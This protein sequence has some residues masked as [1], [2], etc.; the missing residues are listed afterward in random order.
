MEQPERTVAGEVEPTQ[1]TD[2]E[3]LYT[4]LSTL[5]LPVLMQKTEKRLSRLTAQ[6]QRPAHN[7][8]GQINEPSRGRV[9]CNELLGGPLSASHPLGRLLLVHCHQPSG[10][11][12]HSRSSE[13]AISSVKNDLMLSHCPMTEPSLSMDNIRPPTRK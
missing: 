11:L 2:R 13:A 9:R 12:K 7:G 6:V 1:S 5:P 4:R 8:I 3:N 10:V